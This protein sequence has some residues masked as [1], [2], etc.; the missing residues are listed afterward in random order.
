MNILEPLDI[1][2]LFRVAERLGL[3]R[4]GRYP[5]TIPAA[6]NRAFMLTVYALDHQTANLLVLHLMNGRPLIGSTLKTVE[7]LSDADIDMIFSVTVGYLSGLLDTDD[8]YTTTMNKL[9]D[10]RFYNQTDF[11]DSI[12]TFVRHSKQ[13]LPPV[14]AFAKLRATNEAFLG[15]YRASAQLPDGSALM[16]AECALAQLLADEET[17]LYNLRQAQ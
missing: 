17:L 2:N 5:M 10:F 4:T 6:M 11:I 3:Y 13:A 14:E 9:A 15:L 7:N 12:R 8:H 1:P 16:H